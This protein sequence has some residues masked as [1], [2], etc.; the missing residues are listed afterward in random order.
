MR[1][2]FKLLFQFRVMVNGSPG[3]YRKC[4]ERY[5]MI[6][7]VDDCMKAVDQIY[8]YAKEKKHSYYNAGGNKV[9]FEFVGVIDFILM[10]IECEDNEV[11]YD[12]VTLKQPMENKAKLTIS[13]SDIKKKIKQSFLRD[14]EPIRWNESKTSHTNIG[15]AYWELFGESERPDTEEVS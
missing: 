3:T 5:V 8:A 11:W 14:K 13:K 15:V 7:D 12:Y 6:D 10:D 9:H 1:I 4:E 2:A